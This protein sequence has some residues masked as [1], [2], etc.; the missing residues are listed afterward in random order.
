MV[1]CETPTRGR[2]VLMD[3]S[4][5]GAMNDVATDLICDDQTWISP[6]ER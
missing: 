1:I 2:A 6:S 4:S 5:G 3:L